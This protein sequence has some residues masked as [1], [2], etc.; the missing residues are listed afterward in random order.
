MSDVEN[1]WRFSTINNQHQKTPKQQNHKGTTKKIS[2]SESHTQQQ[3]LSAS[4]LEMP[5]G[6]L[7]HYWP[8]FG[9]II[10]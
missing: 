2:K 5:G 4:R 10:V 3:F 9:F 1:Q 7:S 6:Q 8:P